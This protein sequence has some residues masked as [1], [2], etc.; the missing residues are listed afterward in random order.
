MFPNALDT[1]GYPKPGFLRGS[2]TI[3]ECYDDGKL[4]NHGSIKLRLQ[5][6][7]EKSFQ[8]HSFYV[9]ET[10]T[11][12]PIIIGHPASIRLGLIWVLCKNI[13]KSVLAIEKTENSSKNS[14]QD[15]RLKIDGKT[16]WKQQR[17]KSESSVH[18][19]QD[20]SDDLHGENGNK[21]PN[22][23]SF[24][25]IHQENTGKSVLS[26]PSSDG[27]RNDTS[28]MTMGENDQIST[29][30][31]TIANRVKNLNP[32]YMVPID[33]ASHIISDPKSRKKAQLV[34]E[35]AVH[36][37]QDQDSTP[38]TWSQDQ[39]PST[40]PGIFKH[41]SPTALTASETCRVSM[42]SR[43]T[44]QSHQSSTEGGKF[45]SSTR[46]RSRRS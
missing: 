38:S 42:T 13:S 33:E 19:F 40:V 26:R 39:C 8:H 12:K 17:I 7:L 46:R 43:Q 41:C 22:E 34:T 44:Q 4:I 5:H 30:F 1:N 45:P 3:L 37:L 16:P 6:Y 14:F 15:H 11:L 35:T 36:H 29:P 23:D 2:K 20:H 32:W 21:C 28:F 27:S 25:T 31:K 9:V 10:K 24:K 18:S